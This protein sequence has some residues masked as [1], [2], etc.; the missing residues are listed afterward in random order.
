M[1]VFTV[2][3][4]VPFLPTLAAALA[5]GTLL[6][7][8]KVEDEALAD[9]T[10]FLPT[11]RAARALS[12]VLAERAGGRPRL[13]PRI[14]PLGEADEAEFDLAARA[15]EGADVLPPPIP[16]LERRLVLARLVQAWVASVRRADLDLPGDGPLLVPSSPADAVALAADLEALMD[17][18]ATEGV[19]WSD[20]GK[21]VDGDFSRFFELTQRFVA[22]AA[23]HWPDILKARGASDPARRRIAL[24]EAEAARLARERPQAPIIAAGSTGSVPATARLL[25]AIAALPNGAVVLPGLDLDLDEQGWT[26]IGQAADGDLVHG[27]PQATMRRLLDAHLRLARGEVRVL[28][29]AEPAGAAR[30]RVLSQALRPA[31]TTDRW[32]ALDPD[33]RAA[34]AEAGCAGLKLVEA[35]DERDEALAAAIA[36]R[37]TLAEPGHTVALVTPDRGLAVRVAAELA[38]WDIVAEDSAGCALADTPAGRLARLAAEA[39]TKNFDAGSV[40]ALLAHP[41]VRLGLEREA[42][43][44]AAQA[45]ELGVLRGPEPGPGLEGIEEALKTRRE[46]TDWRTPRPARR[47]TA[48][49]WEAAADLV[50]RLGEAFAGFA[51]TDGEVDLIALA[52]L[53]QAAVERL[54]DGPAAEDDPEDGQAALDALFDE[55]ALADAGGVAGR[56]SDYPD[57]FRALAAGKVLPPTRSGHPRVQILGPLEARLLTFDRVV[58]GGLDEGVWPPTARTDAFLNRPMRAQLGLSPPERRIGQSA[59][60]FAQLLGTAD[61]VVTRAAKRGNAPTVPSRFLQRLKAFVGKP[62]WEAVAASGERFRRLARLLDTPPPGRPCPRPVPKPDPGRFPR[63][64]SVTAIETLVRDPYSIFARHVLGL[65][66]LDAVAESPGAADRGMIVHKVL[67]EFGRAFPDAL[68]PDARERLLALGREAFAPLQAAYPELFAAWWPRFERIAEAFLGWEAERRPGIA[69]VLAERKG[70]LTI[71]LPDGGAFL[72]TARA[73]RIEARRDGGFTLVDFKTGTTPSAKEVFAGFSPQLTLEAAILLAGGFEGLRATETPDLL[74]VRVTGG[75]T[76]LEPR[77]VEPQKDETRTVAALVPEH[78]AKLEA[79]LARYVR[80]EIGY[81]SRPF[82][83]YQ[84]RYSEFDH[85]ARVKE[86]S[87][88]AEDPA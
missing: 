45:L 71:P 7:G 10:I 84:R 1:R 79:L 39:A 82:P 6:D 52:G 73:D 55:L 13:M 22:I 9:A 17:A 21:A 8:L 19:P 28:G 76:P 62:A 38:R 47:L 46:E 49:D 43:E 58:L 74:Y 77:P 85:L 65:E 66:A 44:R 41:A 4:A 16:P 60:D 30:A 63:R 75:R 33:E 51:R 27:H 20:L 2:P 32:S 3:A 26:A 29:A 35:A 78:R 53:H 5:D 34:L 48:A 69:Q 37:E 25:A 54:R 87:L 31:E 50:R 15:D 23:E 59:H 67:E 14:V 36:I 72:L 11:R 80:G 57:F 61:A 68:P 86:W 56:F 88:A 40:L 83:K 18:F 24:I 81:M 12:A 42:V 70:E 64:L